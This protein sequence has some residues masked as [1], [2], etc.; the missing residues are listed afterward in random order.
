MYHFP[1]LSLNFLICKKR[2]GGINTEP[3]QDE[4]GWS[5]PP[6]PGVCWISASLAAGRRGEDKINLE[7]GAQLFTADRLQICY[8]S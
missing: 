4:V 1:S 5:L 7:P 8:F 2:V 3:Q 6:Q